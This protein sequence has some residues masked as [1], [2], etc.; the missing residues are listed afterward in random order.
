[1][2]GVSLSIQLMLELPRSAWPGMMFGIRV[3]NNFRAMGALGE[4]DAPPACAR[5]REVTMIGQQEWEREYREWTTRARPFLDAQQWKEAFALG[6]PYVVN[7]SPPLTPLAKP[8]LSCSVFPITSGG[9][10]LKGSQPP[11]AAAD[12]EGDESYRVVPTSL[13]PAAI[14]VAHGHYDPTDALADVNSVFP[15]DRLRELARDGVIGGVTA[16]GISFMG[17]VTNAGHF[18]AHTAREIARQVQESGAD[19]ALLVPV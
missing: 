19:A 4:M 8:L 5:R 9:V 14:A 13:S 6:Y 15:V 10:Y 12:P 11:F 16:V 2:H 7:A 3:G 17:Y 18:A 1:M